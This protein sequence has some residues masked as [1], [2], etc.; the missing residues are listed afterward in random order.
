M[1]LTFV[2]SSNV[3]AIGHE[4]DILEV[5]FRNGAVYH[6]H[7]VPRS[8]Y[9]EFLAALSKGKFVHQRLKNHYAATRIR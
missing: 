7:G 5:H 9:V 3:S 1:T 8:V 6:Y 2:I 4:N